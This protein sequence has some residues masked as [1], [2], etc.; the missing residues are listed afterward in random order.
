MVGFQNTN[1]FGEAG[2]ENSGK[3][4]LEGSA[5]ANPQCPQCQSS[6]AWRDGHRETPLGEQIQR[7]SCRDCGYRFSDPNDLEKTRNET[8]KLEAKISKATSDI[9]VTRQICVEETKNLGSVT[10][11]KTVAEIA[12]RIR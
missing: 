12:A 9:I 4:D 1:I 3:S 6:R 10:E 8:R 2:Q 5:G 7:W 11:T